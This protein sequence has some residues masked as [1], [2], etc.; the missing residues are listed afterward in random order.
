MVTLPSW[1]V[2]EGI[3][4]A[5]D[6]NSPVRRSNPE[7]V[8][9][10]AAERHLETLPTPTVTIWSDSSVDSD[11]TNGG[12]GAAIYLADGSERAL[13]VPAG[14][15]C[16]SCGAE[17]V[18]LRA[19]L[20]ELILLACIGPSDRVLVCTDSQSSLA[21]LQVGPEAQR[22]VIGADVW[23][24]LPNGDGERRRAGPPATG[25]G[26]LWTAKGMRSQTPWP[27]RRLSSRSRTSRR[28]PRLS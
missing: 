12:G 15:V 27:R 11:T 1:E 20:E 18:S 19:A 25:T 8:R 23:R 16:S 17:M 5:T 10:A 24:Y 9:R 14:S 22:S 13:R 21:L 28:T 26:T 2:P 4:I 7:V 3:T 6:I